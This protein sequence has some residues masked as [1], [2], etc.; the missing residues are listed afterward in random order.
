MT[1]WIFQLNP[2]RFDIAASDEADRPRRFNVARYRD[3][4]RPGD[5]AAIWESGPHAGVYGLATIAANE[6]GEPDIYERV[7]EPNSGFRHEEDIGQR[8]VTVNFRDDARWLDKPILRSILKGDPRFEDAPI[9]IAPFQGNPF[10]VTD[11]QWRAIT[12]RLS[13]DDDYPN[14]RIIN[15]YKETDKYE[16]LQ[17]PG[18]YAY[19]LPWIIKN[20]NKD[21]NIL[22]KVGRSERVF[23]R[24]EALA[25]ATEAPEKMVLLAVWATDN[26]KE[27][28]DTFH[29][30]LI[31]AGHPRSTGGHEWFVTNLDYLKAIGEAL[32]LKTAFINEEIEEIGLGES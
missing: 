8:M 26:P 24:V 28:E 12:S 7:I 29:K 15:A 21:G 17:I 9:L 27:T 3:Q 22:I 10:P 25:R 11:D 19:S 6:A 13:D 16:Q 2:D 18:V 32:A 1:N 30:L 14:E 20:P 5:S 4:L 31:K 23:D